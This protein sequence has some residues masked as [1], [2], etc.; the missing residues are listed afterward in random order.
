MK[1][2]V[3]ES[4]KAAV[5]ESTLAGDLFEESMSSVEIELAREAVEMLAE[6]VL[7]SRVDE[8]L[9]SPENAMLTMRNR[10]HHC[11]YE[12]GRVDET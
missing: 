12:R 4:M 10:C 9:T 5:V 7:P 3:V 2:P 1:A 11:S 6:V 8:T